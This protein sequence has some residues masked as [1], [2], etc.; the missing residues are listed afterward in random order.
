MSSSRAITFRYSH[1]LRSGVALEVLQL[2]WSDELPETGASTA[3]ALRET[4]ELLRQLQRD[5]PTSLPD[6]LA[7]LAPWRSTYLAEKRLSTHAFPVLQVAVTTETDLSALELF[8][9]HTSP[10]SSQRP[11]VEIFLHLDVFHSS[12]EGQ[13]AL[14]LRVESLLIEMPAQALLLRVESLLIEMP[15]QGFRVTM[16]W[17]AFSQ[18]RV[19]DDA[20]ASVLQRVCS[21][22]LCSPDIN[23]FHVDLALPSSAS[24]QCS[25]EAWHSLFQVLGRVDWPP[26]DST[27]RLDVAFH[28]SSDPHYSV[29]D[30]QLVAAFMSMLA[31]SQGYGRVHLSSTIDSADAGRAI[32]VT[33]VLTLFQSCPLLHDAK[34]HE[35]DYT[36]PLPEFAPTSLVARR[37]MKLQVSISRDTSEAPSNVEYYY[38]AVE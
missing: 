29:A 21:L 37:L 6:A 31:K 17:L 33:A 12:T 13:R 2:N 7:T 30:H 4:V 32:P 24:S 5:E 38:V 8:V 34:L 10:I 26:L 36:Q 14:L 28:G 19:V 16:A 22:V 18:L 11:V 20:M 15:A 3:S 27:N 25:L 1:P 9:Q 35:L 23:S